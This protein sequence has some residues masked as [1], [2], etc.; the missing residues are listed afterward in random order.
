M[1]TTDITLRDTLVS[2]NRAWLTP[3]TAQIQDVLV[4]DQPFH[5]T[6]KY[7]NPGKEPASGFAAQEDVG[8]I[9][10]LPTPQTSLYSVFHKS[11]LKDVCKRTKASEDG[12]IV[13]PSSSTNNYT[14]DVTTD[15]FKIT[16]EILNRRQ[17]IFVH[18]CFAYLSFSEERKSEYCF[19]FL[20]RDSEFRAVACPYGNHAN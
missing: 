9:N 7:G 16:P 15:D 1:R 14:Y 6:V 4:T 19:V 11:N 2:T 20:P 8:T 10:A 3:V 18:G 17:L 5:F 13:Y 12:S